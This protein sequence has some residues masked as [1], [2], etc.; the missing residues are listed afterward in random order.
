[1]PNKS[2][3]FIN[4]SK[5]WGGGEKW[6]FDNALFLAEKDYSVHVITNVNSTLYNELNKKTNIKTNQL[7]ISNFSFVNPLRVI[8]VIKLLKK[9]NPD[10]VIINLPS[11]LKLL[12]TALCFF[13]IKNIIYRRGSAIAVKNSILNRY[14]F[15]NVITCIIVNSLATKQTLLQNNSNLIDENKIKLIYNGIDLKPYLDNK[16][17]TRKKTS[18][19]LTIGHIGRFSEEKN[20]T[21]L[22]DVAHQLKKKKIPFHFL[23]GGDGPDFHKIK[24]LI[25]KRNLTENFTLPGFI[26]NTSEFIKSIDVF[27]LPSFWEGFGYVTIEAMANEKPVIAFNITSNREVIENNV[28]GFLTPKNDLKTFVEKINF[29]YNYPEKAYEMGKQGKLRVIKYFNIQDRFIEFEN[30]IKRL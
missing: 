11:D 5:T 19:E 30:F 20:Q 4:S 23:L 8:Q 25:K 2:I 17:K 24:T 29:F 3:C 22:V 16:T 9:I 18:K 14:I 6:H 12:A 15:K 21:F 26:K 7:K 1:M 28:T 27:V 10:T 13:Y